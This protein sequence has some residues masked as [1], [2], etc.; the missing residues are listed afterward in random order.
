MQAD[1][2]VIMYFQRERKKERNRRGILRFYFQLIVW[3]IINHDVMNKH[4]RED[5]LVNN[6]SLILIN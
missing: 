2:Y 3:N 6:K 1:N 4:N 5:M